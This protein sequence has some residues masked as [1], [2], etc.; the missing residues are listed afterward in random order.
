MNYGLP[1]KGSKNALA[2]RIVECIPS[3]PAFVD[4]FCGGCAVTHA[5]ML[6]G[7]WDRYIANDICGIVPRAFLDAVSGKYRGEDRWISREEFFRLKDTD[8]YVRCCWSF[9][10]NGRDYIYSRGVEPYKRALHHAV[11][12]RD[13]GPLRE[14]MPE[15]SGE[16]ERRLDRLENRKERR[17]EIGRGIVAALNA[18][19][20]EER[21]RLIAANPLYKMIRGQSLESLESLERLERLERLESLQSLRI[22]SM[23]YREVRLP[24]GCVVYCDPPYKGTD[25]YNHQGFDHDAFWEW[26][27][28]CP[29][30]VYVSEYDAPKDFV[31]AADFPH[32]SRISATAN[33]K[34]TERLFVHESRYDELKTRLIWD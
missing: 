28:N 26:A 2:W 24:E 33:N 8:G 9:G 27:R 3:A 29:R 32:R 18:L 10:N 21:S 12:W 11:F 5:A 13:Y 14:L 15:V 4:L 34:V 25:G 7:R 16:V 23:D 17:V 30:P 22:S 6:A 1:Y 19:A 31:P 20:S